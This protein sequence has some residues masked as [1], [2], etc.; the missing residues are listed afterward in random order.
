MVSYSFSSWS[1]ASPNVFSLLSRPAR[2]AA[3]G[4]IPVF[5]ELLGLAEF[6][7]FGGAAMLVAVQ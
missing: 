6:F 1:A 5:G 7:F 3:Q 2:F 4:Q